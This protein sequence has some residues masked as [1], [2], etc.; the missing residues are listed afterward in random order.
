[1]TENP[2]Q[3]IDIVGLA[4]ELAA[5]ARIC[6]QRR[7]LVLSG[8]AAWCRKTAQAVCADIP[9]METVWMSSQAPRGVDVVEGRQA[10]A[11]LGQERDAVIFDAHSGFDVDAFGAASGTVRGGG[12]LILLAPPLE[13]WPQFADPACESIAVAPYSYADVSG[14]FLRR[15]VRVIESS[16][17]VIVVRQDAPLPQLAPQKKASAARVFDDV[18]RSADQRRAVEAVLHVVRGH[19]R[20]PAV[21]ISDRG[22]G[23]SAALGIAA[24]QLLQEGVRHIVVTAPRPEAV[25]PLFAQVQAMLPQA[26]VKQNRIRDGEGVVEFHPPDELCLTNIAADLLL[27][28]EAAAIPVSLL[29]RLLERYSRIAFA[30]TVHGYE[31]TGRGF[32]VRFRRTLD[33]RTP[34]WCEVKLQTPIRWAEDDPVERFIFRALLLDAEGSSNAAVAQLSLEDCEYV[35]LDRD[36]LADDEAT[37]AQLFGLL[38]SAHYRTRP[39]DLRNLLDGPNLAV[40]IVRGEGQVVAAAL[41]TMEGG[42]D[43]ATAQAIAEGKRRPRGHLI[44]QSLAAH[45]GLTQAAQLRCAR[46]M[47]IAVHPAAQRRGVGARLVA[48]IQND[49]AAQGV[50]FAGASFGATEELLSFWHNA[51]WLPVRIGFSRDHTS[52]SHSVMVLHPLTPAG[53]VVY[54]A[55][56]TRFVDSFPH[57][58]SDPLRD[59]EA[60]LAAALLGREP[61]MMSTLLSAAEREEVRQFASGQRDYAECMVALWQLGRAV[62]SDAFPRL[63]AVECEVFMAKVLQKRSWPEVVALSGLA[64]R[65]EAVSVLRNSARVLLDYASNKRW[66]GE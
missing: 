25:A 64:G 37:L 8:D 16:E 26:E 21:L 5:Q 62:S 35:R 1:M 18:Y 63:R 49:V 22:R 47:R 14:R 30:T 7:A 32:A 23:K 27:V 10:D 52:G 20:R 2:A 40:Y 3:E 46:I 12:L 57:W 53:E 58:L 29:Q 4:R 66:S 15:L 36:A 56:R 19:R 34:G 61:G 54:A 6:F 28:D 41:V 65:A 55:A 45:A 24:A 59:L 33:E 44:P 60:G 13:T 51:K 39:T 31:G 9:L 43:A 38:V 11:L 48:R 42:F 17:G 50:D